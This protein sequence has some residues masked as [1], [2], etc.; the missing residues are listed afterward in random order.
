[1][2]KSFLILFIALA[3]VISAA[4]AAPA[5]HA[6]DTCTNAGTPCTAA[7]GSAGSCAADPE[8]NGY[9]CLPSAYGTAT[10]SN[11]GGS[12]DPAA[13]KQGLDNNK[14][15]DSAYSYVMQK[16]MTLFAWLVGVAALTLDYAVYYTVVTM[17]DYIKN[18]SAVGVTWRILRDIGN[19]VLIFGFLAVGITT[20]LNVDWYGGGKKMLPMMFVAAVFLNFSLFISEAIVDTGNLFATQFFTQ[21]NG[22]SLPTSGPLG[23]TSNGVVLTTENEGISNKIMAQLGLQA[24]Y[25]A[26][27]APN[28]EIFKA[29]NTWLIGFMGIILFLVVAFVMFSLAFILIA[30]FIALIFL[31]IA[32]PLGFAGLAMPGFVNLAGKYWKALFEQTITAPILLLMLYI[33]LRVITDDLFMTGF[34]S[35]TNPTGW[36][37]FI[38]NGTNMSNL[39]GFASLVLSFLVAMGL[40]LAVVVYAKRWSAFG[41]DWATRTAGKLTFGLAGAGMRTTAGWGSQY[42][43]KKVEGSRLGRIP[44][45]GRSLLGVLDR[46]AKASFDVRGSGVLKKIPF[47]SQIDTGEAQKGGYRKELETAIKGREDHAKRL[48]LTSGEK[49]KQAEEERRKRMME[50]TVKDIE[51]QNK[52]EIDNLVNTHAVDIQRF[53]QAVD[54]ERAALRVAQTGGNQVTIS[55]AQLA[56]NTALLDQQREREKQNKEREELKKVHDR[57]IKVQQAEVVARQEEVNKIKRAPQEQYA[58]GLE[59]VPWGLLYR[60][61]KAAANIRK[62]AGKSKEEKD[63]DTLMDLLKK[64]SAST[65]ASAVSAPTPPATGG[66]PHP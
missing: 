12:I 58:A 61:S 44:V 39:P 17:G 27:L 18:L 8:T 7:D 37:G 42:L 52:T 57:L 48:E 9:Y 64:N 50:Q 66:A 1:M 3:L 25:G 46:G 56:L 51:D 10:A 2:R 59:I 28:T 4:G 26:A 53:N 32:S 38:Q 20:I 24:I 55:A 45:V 16:I 40:L 62:T 65:P 33:A 30:R 36:T 19:I 41:G 49:A 29:G 21:I 23:L 43:S 31:I 14:S 63:V 15:A 5:A 35:S 60:N 54:Q 22:G 13:A 47:G 34:G 6:A 11:P